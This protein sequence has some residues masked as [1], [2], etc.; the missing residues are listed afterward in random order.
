MQQTPLQRSEEE[1]VV[2]SDVHGVRTSISW[3]QYTNENGHAVL[4]VSV[5]ILHLKVDIHTLL[6]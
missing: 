6:C 2:L 1:T 3:E 4:R 5:Q